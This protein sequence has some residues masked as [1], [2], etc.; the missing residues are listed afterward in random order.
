MRQLKNNTTKQVMTAMIKERKDGGCLEKRFGCTA[1]SL[2][3]IEYSL[4]Y[5]KHIMVWI[6]K[7]F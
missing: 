4:A 5:K 2:N 7:E 1:S 6:V 3:L